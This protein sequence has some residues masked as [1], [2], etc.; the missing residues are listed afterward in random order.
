[1]PDVKASVAIVG[2]NQVAAAFRGAVRDAQSAADRMSSLFKTAFAGISVAAIAGLVK[3]T[4]NLGEQIG[5]AAQKAGLGTKDFSELAYAAKRDNIEIEALS[6][7]FKAMQV[8]LSNAS[9][10]GKDQTLTLHALG[11]EFKDLQG[12]KPDQQFELL[13]QRI[14]ELKDPADRTRASVELFGKAGADLLPMFEK[15]AAGIRKA[16]EEAKQLGQSFDETT[17]NHLREAEEAGKKLEASW[18]AFA[19]TMTA[20]VSPAIASV[21]D[22]LRIM[23]GGASQIESLK[24][25]IEDLEQTGARLA[26]WDPQG[27]ARILKQISAAKQQLFELEQARLTAEHPDRRSMPG[28][29]EQK[30]PGFAAASAAENAAKEAKKWNDWFTKQRHDTEDKFDAAYIEKSVDTEAAAAE[31]KNDVYFQA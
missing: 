1:M 20:K 2:E 21:L 8:S 24:G 3:Q 23:A 19:V 29:Q 14:S 11:L 28:A 12:L 17:I 15:G 26:N 22:K 4:I 10:G 9:Q 18:G 7:A 30:A 6:K 25:Q 13:A 5:L 27:F 31:R 16:R